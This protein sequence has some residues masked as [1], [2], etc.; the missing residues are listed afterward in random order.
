MKKVIISVT[1]DLST[2]QRVDRV[3]NTLLSMGFDVCLVGRKLKGS[4]PLERNYKTHRMNLLFKRGPLFYAEYNKRLFLY[5]I[6]HK[7][8]LLVSNDLDTLTANFLAHK[9]KSIPLVYDS[10]E[11]YTGTPE[12]INRPHIQS[13]WKAIE[14]FIFPKLKDVFTV[15]ESIANIYSKEYN[16]QLHVV[17]NV[18]KK[19]IEK[20]QLNAA[21]LSLGN[22]KHLIILQGAGINIQRGAEEAILAMQ[23]IEDSLLLIVGN[24]DVIP[25]LKELVTLKNL[26]DKVTFLPKKPY[27]ELMMYTAAA[28]IGLTLDKDT[29][30]NYRFSLPNKL[31]DYIHAGTPVLASA[32]PEI[33]KIID[34][35][36]VGITIE[37]HD[38]E[39]IATKIKYM[40]V[41]DLKTKLQSNLEIAANDLNWEN[42]EK[43]LK[44]VYLKY[45]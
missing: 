36:H 28:D 8:D 30:I 32:L 34:K 23:F 37:S 2:D 12:L 33:S 11:Y 35:Y 19:L 39:H 4:L 9:L 40:L 45:V 29:N 16:K 10:H 43:I 20:P 3:C 6:F 21:D 27:K 38:P 41:N 17:R 44:Q 1:N 24:G 42:E 31:F 22:K 13:F 25:K 26:S 5:L 15:N 18:P 14:K 7:A